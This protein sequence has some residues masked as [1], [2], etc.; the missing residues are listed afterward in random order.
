M[1]G[2][3]LFAWL[4]LKGSGTAGSA[5]AEP[6]QGGIVKQMTLKGRDGRTYRLTFYGDQTRLVDTD[7]AVFYVNARGPSRGSK[8][9]AVVK[10]VKGDQAAVSD[11]LANLPE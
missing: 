11:A 9:D 8:M 2:K 4:L 3:L 10:V 5:S 1:W 7:A 6:G